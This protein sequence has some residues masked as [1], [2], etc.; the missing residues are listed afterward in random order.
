MPAKSL[1]LLPFSCSTHSAA[2]ACKACE[3]A[4]MAWRK[5]GA[6]RSCHQSVRCRR[7]WSRSARCCSSCRFEFRSSQLRSDA[8]RTALPPL[9]TVQMLTVWCSCGLC[10]L[11][12]RCG[13]GVEW[14]LSTSSVQRRAALRE[15][16][17]SP[18]PLQGKAASTRF[19]ARLPALLQPSASRNQA[20]A[21]A[22]AAEGSLRHSAVD[23]AVE[24]TEA[25]ALRHR[26]SI[27]ADRLPYGSIESA[28]AHHS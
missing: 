28:T 5:H 27:A 14:G 10:M 20:C 6:T 23:T 13:T 1:A 7:H 16:R 9:I 8:A 18:Q 12:C 22:A 24:A 25:A 21:Q 19:R 15:L 2:A 11:L 4:Y 17:T 26:R 3:H